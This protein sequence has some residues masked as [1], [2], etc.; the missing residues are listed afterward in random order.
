[1]KKLEFIKEL[2][3]RLKG[4]PKDVVDNAVNYYSECI[5][6]AVEDGRNE[7]EAVRALGSMDE[8]VRN[9][10]KDV[11][12]SKLVKNKVKP[13]HRLNAFEII[14]LIIGFP[15]WFPLLM[16]ACAI[17]FAFYVVLWSLF[18]AFAATAFGLVAGGLVALIA[19]FPA[20]GAGIP[21]KRGTRT[22]IDGKGNIF[23]GGIDQKF[24]QIDW[25]NSHY[26]TREIKLNDVLITSGRLLPE[27]T[28]LR[29]VIE[30]RGFTDGRFEEKNGNGGN[31]H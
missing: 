15:L 4:Y 5:D 1:M 26:A 17:F 18:I 7:E 27:H 12:L 19:S 20:F 13:D 16:T 11:P 21:E 10:L 3:S 28:R 8:I 23:M 31:A 9:T 25:L 2:R 24:P 22:W 29:L 6:D 14:I 30:K